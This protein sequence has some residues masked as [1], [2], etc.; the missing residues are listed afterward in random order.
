MDEVSKIYHV[1]AKTISHKMA[2]KEQN[3]ALSNFSFD[4]ITSEGQ[5]GFPP[6]G[7]L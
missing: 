5:N 2:S 1:K 4:A 7:F 6:L 3:E